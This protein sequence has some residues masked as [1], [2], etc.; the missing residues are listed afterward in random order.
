MTKNINIS[1]YF[2][3]VVALIATFGSLFFSEVM[4]FVPCTLC[5]YQRIG[6]YPLVLILGQGLLTKNALQSA[7]FA[8]T[9]AF[10]G[11]FFAIYH[12]LLHVGVISEEMTPCS[13][14]IPCSTKYIQW[15]GFLSIPL[16]SLI[17]F[18]LIVGAL[19]YFMFKRR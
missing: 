19:S 3:W 11:W 4:H 14:G 7:K 15:F 5:W 16:L 12:T 13:Q 10:V 2:A 1:V 6:M 8:L 17:A 18:T 9:L